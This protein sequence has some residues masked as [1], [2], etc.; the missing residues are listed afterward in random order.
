MTTAQ[1]DQAFSGSGCAAADKALYGD[2]GTCLSNLTV[3][4]DKLNGLSSTCQ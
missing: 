3:C 4:T 1:C 2:F